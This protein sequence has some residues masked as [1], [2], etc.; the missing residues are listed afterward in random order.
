MKKYV[1]ASILLLL[2][3]NLALAEGDN[4]L[5]LYDSLELQL[6]V[7]GVVE[8]VPESSSS[9]VKELTAEL[10]LFPQEDYRQKVLGMNTGAGEVKANTVLYTWNDKKFGEKDFGY[11]ANI[12]TYNERIK[13]E[14][15]VPFPLQDIP[16]GLSTYTL[17]SETIDSE[18][19]E[20]IAKAAELAE[21]EDDV[22]KVAFKLASWVEENVKYDLNSLTSKASQKASWVLENKEGVCD[23]MTSLFVAMARSQGIPARFVSGVSYTT[24]GL[25]NENWQPHA[26]AEVYFPE[27][28][29]V[30]F[31]IAFGEYGYVDVTHIKLRDSVDS[32]EPATKFEWLGKEVSLNTG[33]LKL[34][35]NILDKIGEQSEEIQLEQ[36]ILGKVVD[37]GSYNLIKGVVKN[38][39]GYYA[40]TTLQLAVPKE[41]NILGRNKR[42]I[43]LAPKEVKETYWIIKAPSNF[44]PN[45]WYTFPTLIY[46][47][48]NVSVS[49][50]FKVQKGNIIYSEK[51]VRQLVVIPEDKTYSRKVSLSCNLPKELFQD[52]E[53]K[54]NC[55]IKNIGNAN[56]D[57]VNF[58]VGGVCEFVDLPINQYKVN[59]IKIKTDKIGWNKLMVSA[60][61]KLIDKKVGFEYAVFD[62][63]ELELKVNYPETITFGG[64]FKVDLSMNK[65]SF[66]A[67]QKVKVTIFGAGFEQKFEL[68]ELKEPE[69]VSAEL[70]TDR[71]SR[72]NKY[73]VEVKWEDKAGEQYSKTQEIIVAGK[74]NSLTEKAKILLN[75]LLGVFAG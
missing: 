67:P 39:A 65:T 53:R 61:N 8:L 49:D 50:E 23:E 11:S 33:D 56:L 74:G 68:E 40:A 47:E 32:I 51:E 44:N 35:V 57:Q 41:I 12:N 60:E 63:P 55:T 38:N 9:T 70:R 71:I 16:D 26:W 69:D 13:V 24:S 30:S 75:S 59:Q 46:N 21:G 5:Y 36:E 42:T 25:F 19:P 2:A 45:Y 1:I 22:F 64:D 7:T 20:I 10:K 37:L 66:S 29:W 62:T 14:F 31:D 34:N 3:P 43:L 48:K 58:C 27:V 15:K 6:D 17:P 52:E 28:G 73:Q 54:V 18:N 4:N 72:T